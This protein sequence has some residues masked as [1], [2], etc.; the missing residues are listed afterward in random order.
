MMLLKLMV[1]VAATLA[2]KYIIGEWAWTAF[3]VGTTWDI[4]LSPTFLI[5][6]RNS[7]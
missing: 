1:L 5:G 4:D 7:S 2:A 3:L 6:D